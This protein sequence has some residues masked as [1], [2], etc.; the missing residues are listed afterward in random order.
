MNDSKLFT[1]EEAR[2]L[3]PEL[4]NMLVLA[5]DQLD[6]LAIKLEGASEAYNEIE[7]RLAKVKTP[8]SEP[9][10]LNKLRTC[11]DQFQDAIKD[12]STA[13]QE[14]SDCFNTWVDRITATGVILRDI[15]NGLL[16]FPACTGDVHYFLCWKLGEKDIEYWHLCTDG[17]V[18]R[19]P[20]AVLDEYF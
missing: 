11:R 8:R 14:L 7:E 4:K 10:D 9:A 12:L 20:L 5:N 1:L 18:G 2:S 19:R 16:D 15:R 13:Q 6:E 3:L 17:F